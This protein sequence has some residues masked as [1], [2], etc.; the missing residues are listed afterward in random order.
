MDRIKENLL[1]MVDLIERTGAKAVI[2]G[3][4]L[5]PSYG[6]RYID[7]F[8]QVFRDVAAIRQLP[9]IDLYREDFL[10]KPGYIQEDGLH[11]TEI[12]QPIIRDSLLDFF[13]EHRIFE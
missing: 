2:A 12:T 11:P 4:S 6:P 13:A 1:G 9:Y 5:P 7:Q 3:I 8:R 10:S